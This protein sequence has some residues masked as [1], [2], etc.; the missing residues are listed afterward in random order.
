MK[1]N[2]EIRFST[3]KEFHSIAIDFVKEQILMSLFKVESGQTVISRK[4]KVVAKEFLERVKKRQFKLSRENGFKFSANREYV[5]SDELENKIDRFNKCFSKLLESCDLL[6]GDHGEK[7][8]IGS[9]R[10]TYGT[11]R[12]NLDEVD[13][14][15]LA[16]QMG[17][18][19]EMINKHY[20]HSDDYDRST[21]VTRVKK[22]ANPS[23]KKKIVK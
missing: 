12:K 13:S 6:Y 17:T 21:A 1:N 23:V 4:F 14:Y 3:G 18:S 8:V 15:E 19:P 16:I 7:R 20:V 11:F 2:L 9:L 10:H 5:W 22:S